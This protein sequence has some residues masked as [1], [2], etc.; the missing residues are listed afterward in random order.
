MSD[1]HK[2][3]HE[4]N[5]GLEKMKD[6]LA[7]KRGR[8]YWRT[9]GEMS[10][11]PEFQRFLEDEFP[12]RKSLLEIDRRSLLKFMGASMALAGLSGC[13]SVFLPEDKIV[14]YVKQPE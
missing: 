3:D 12:N 14:P 2:H 7:G 1:F 8:T 13:R 5:P 4:A 10:D 11:T 9:L 6:E